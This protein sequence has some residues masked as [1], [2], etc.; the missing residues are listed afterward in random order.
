MEKRGGNFMTDRRLREATY[1]LFSIFCMGI[2]G[3]FL[4]L[5]MVPIAIFWIALSSGFMGFGFCLWLFRD[6]IWGRP[7]V[8]ERWLYECPEDVIVRF[9]AQPSLTGDTPCGVQVQD[10]E[11]APT[12]CDY[13]GALQLAQELWFHHDRN[14]SVDVKILQPHNTRE[15]VR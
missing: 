10:V 1:F 15:I 2:L 5:V 3:A 8:V 6:R 9:R 4:Y 13:R 14:Y 12:P 11:P 7:L